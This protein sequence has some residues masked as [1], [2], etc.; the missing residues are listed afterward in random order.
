MFEINKRLD[1]D[2]KDQ[3]NKEDQLIPNLNNNYEEDDSNK[4]QNQPQETLINEEI[5]QI[6]SNEIKIPYQSK[7]IL[8]D[9]K[10]RQNKSSISGPSINNV[11]KQNIIINN[12]N[13]TNN[14]IDPNIEINQNRNKNFQ[15][16]EISN[17]YINYQSNL[18]QNNGLQARQ[19]NRPCWDCLDCAA[20]FLGCSCGFLSIFIM[21][22]I[23]RII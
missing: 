22:Y 14:H 21:P 19:N 16:N 10:N 7:N 3:E 9:K 18:R 6:N 15:N 8:K 12:N 23:Y 11:N 13:I 2:F 17:I 1:V 4:H 20:L 5:I